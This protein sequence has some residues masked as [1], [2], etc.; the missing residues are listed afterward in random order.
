MDKKKNTIRDKQK[1]TLSG[2]EKGNSG[3]IYTAVLIL[4]R[5]YLF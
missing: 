4:L 3:D 5:F 1:K 2:D